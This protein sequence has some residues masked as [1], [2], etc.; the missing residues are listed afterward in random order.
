MEICTAWRWTDTALCLGGVGTERARPRER[1]ILPEPLSRRTR[2]GQVAPAGLPLTGVKAI[3]AGQDFSL[4]LLSNGTVRAWGSNRYHAER[5]PK[6]LTNVTAISAGWTH[7][8]ALKSDGTVV[9]WGIPVVPSGLSNVVAIA[10]GRGTYGENLAL[11]RNGTV[12]EWTAAGFEVPAPAGLTNIAA[13]ASGASHCLALTRSGGML[14]WGANGA[15]QA[16]GSFTSGI[17]IRDAAQ[18]VRIAGRLLT[19][20]VA[21]AAGEESSLALR[22]DGSVIAWGNIFHSPITVP[23]SLTN[24]IAI[25]AGGSFCLA[26]EEP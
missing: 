24:V 21:I 22:S 25:A 14:G 19:N 15:G 4:A 2:A 23:Q 20:V 8:M 1:Q 7:S 10:A 5:V 6:G 9:G 11:R 18:P 3:S 16:T 17:L 12:V 13:I 26:V